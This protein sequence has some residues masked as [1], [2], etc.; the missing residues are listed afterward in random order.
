MDEQKPKRRLADMPV[1]ETH[2]DAKHRRLED[3]FQQTETGP[4]PA[5]MHFSLFQR[6]CRLK[7]ECAGEPAVFPDQQS[8]PE[9]PETSR[10]NT[11]WL[12]LDELVSHDLPESSP[13]GSPRPYRKSES[14]EPV[15]E[16]DQVP[17]AAELAELAAFR[18]EAEEYDLRRMHALL[19]EKEP[20]TDRPFAVEHS[21]RLHTHRYRLRP[22][23]PRLRSSMTVEQLADA[24]VVL[25]ELHQNFCD[26]DWLWEQI[27]GDI[28][29]QTEALRDAYARHY[30]R[31][32]AA[33]GL[34]W[35]I[36]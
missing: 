31:T 34:A 22:T 21:A 5:C 33:Q 25:E 17:T 19:A 27:P 12:V 1:D 11:Q 29:K 35:Q 32:Y 30:T 26:S 20:V 16:A 15:A 14:N 6:S 2:T 7:D 28:R 10:E 23:W 9:A 24:C 18:E 4:N 13:P 8:T 36:G 3:D